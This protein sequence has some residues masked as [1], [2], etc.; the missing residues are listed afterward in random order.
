MKAIHVLSTAPFYAKKPDGNFAVERFELYNTV[1]SALQWRRVNG[2]IYLA[3]DSKGAEYVK[4]I[5]LYK[6]WNDVLPVI[7]DSGEGINQRMFWASGKL[8]ALREIE[9]PVAIVDMDFIVWSKLNFGDRIIC[10]HR[11]ELMP[12][13]YPPKEHFIMKSY[14]YP[15]NLDWSVLPCNTAFCYFPDESFKQYYVNQSIAFMKS[16]VDCDDY[17]CYM[18]FAEQRLLAML[19][20]AVGIGI[21]TLLDKDKLFVPQDG[22]T[23]LWGAKQ[24]M[25]ENIKLCEDFC[26][27]CRVRIKTD[28]PD[29]AYT[30]DL[31]EQQA[32]EHKI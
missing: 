6:I 7:D 31:I 30:I 14:P 5:G 12:H 15:Q 1:I 11:E 22:F 9:G 21:D 20:N 18:V 17:L 29:F 32:F 26:Q 23:H 28:F 27:Q 13:V 19:A 24:K 16:A 8:L 4:N 3:T 10:A 25:R 2:E